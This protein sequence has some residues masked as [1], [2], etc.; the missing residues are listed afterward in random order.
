MEKPTRTAFGSDRVVATPDGTFLVSCRYSKGWV[1]RRD[2]DLVHAV[3]PGTCVRWEEE[4]FEVIGEEALPVGVRYTLRRWDDSQVM[5]LVE[6]YDATS[7]QRRDQVRRQEHTRTSRRRVFWLYALIVG[8]LPA[9]VQQRLQSEYG[10]LAAH[11]TIISAIPW[12]IIG[13]MVALSG[14]RLGIP[15]HFRII[16]LYM[17]LESIVRFRAFLRSRPMGSILGVLPWMIWMLFTGRIPWKKSPP[18]LQCQLEPGLQHLDAYT[19]R[20]PLLALLPPPEQTLLSKRYG[21]DPMRWGRRT[22]MILTVVATLGIITSVTTLQRG[23]D[24]GA[25]VSLAVAAYLLGEQLVRWRSFARGQPAGSVF[26]IL[27]RPFV[28]RLLA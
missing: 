24:F 19:I 4:F 13:L 16:A 15:V 22:A 10:V 11:L 17:S 5:R 27:A 8:N 2:A 12:F 25:I 21:F 14:A 3:F 26:G 20:E 9:S 28:K 18:K 7:E 1:C 6:D 23:A